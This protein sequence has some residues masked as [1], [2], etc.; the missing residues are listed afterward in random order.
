M[1]IKK[2]G[3]VLLAS[4]IG[5]LLCSGVASAIEYGNCCIPDG[6]G[7]DFC[8]CADVDDE[9]ACEL[10]NGIWVDTNGCVRGGTDPATNPCLNYCT[11]GGKCVPE[12]STIV[13]LATGLIGMVG[14]LRL[15][16]KEE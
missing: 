9:A 16:R 5:M 1:S 13:L 2:I 15:R 14:Y 10:A 3:I 4:L 12:M 11:E 6:E 7:A 8:I